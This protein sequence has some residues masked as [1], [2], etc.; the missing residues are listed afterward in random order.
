MVDSVQSR[1]SRPRA[2]FAARLRGEL[3][4]IFRIDL[5]SLALFRV[6]LALLLFAEVCDRASGFSAQYTEQGVV[7]ASALRQLTLLQPSLFFLH[8]GSAW[9][10]FLFAVAALSTILLLIGWHTR[11]ACVVAFVLISSIQARNPLINHHGD[12]LMRFL[13]MWGMFLPLGAVFSLDA[14]SRRVRRRGGSVCSVASAALLLQGLFLYWVVAASKFQYDIWWAGDSLYAVLQKDSYVRPLGEVLVGYPQLLRWLTHASMVTESLL[15]V[16]LFLPWQRDRARTLCVLMAAGFQLSIFAVADIG[17]FQP[18]AILALFPYL[19]AWFWDRFG[20]LRLPEPPPAEPDAPGRARSLGRLAA[21]TLVGLLLA[22][23]VVS[24]LSTFARR[25]VH[26]PGPIASL[27]SWLGLDQR[28]RMFANAG[29]T[30]Q[31]WHVAFGR[32]REG[33]VFELLRGGTPTLSRPEHYSSLMPNNGWRIYWSNISRDRAL[34][35]RPFLGDYL[36][37]EWNRHA[38]PEQRVELVEVI[39]VQKF[40]HSAAETPRIVPRV[41]LRQPCPSQQAAAPASLQ[42]RG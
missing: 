11:I 15:A 1:T 17:T 7:P 24:N 30:L 34:P 3:R 38:D 32:S 6:S 35:F 5:R 33:R 26:L 21:A 23:T 8:D 31:G 41:L 37:R 27:G 36:C 28:W 42:E 22:Y 20:G 13:A 40:A 9:A 4:A 14:R 10:A 18:L 29:A 25:P 39:H 2:L 16:L 19:P 12:A